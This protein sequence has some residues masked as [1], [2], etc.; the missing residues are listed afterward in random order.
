MLKKVI[1]KIKEHPDYG[2]IKLEFWCLIGIV[3][4]GAL[5]DYLGGM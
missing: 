1:K 5:N 4:V 3:V 2:T